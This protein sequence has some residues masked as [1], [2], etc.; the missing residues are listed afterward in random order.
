M[1]MDF[2]AHED[3]ILR[4]LKETFEKSGVEPCDY[5]PRF[6]EGGVLLYFKSLEDAEKGI[7]FF[8]SHEFRGK[9]K[10]V[11]RL[12]G[13]P[14]LEDMLHVTPS[15]LIKVTPAAFK[16]VLSLSEEELY[17]HFRAYGVLKHVEM[18][19]KRE[20]M[21]LTYRALNAAISARICM[22]MKDVATKEYIRVNYEHYSRF[23]WFSKLLSNP[24]IAIPIIAVGGTILS[25]VLI[26]PLR[27]LNVVRTLTSKDTDDAEIHVR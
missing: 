1:G 16:G 20:H 27:L 21:L 22:H 7:S 8:N 26:D 19:P 4:D 18:D 9:K 17:S 11:F 25:Y 5:F 14:W 10:H 6:K 2:T 23:G 15:P 24:R 3:Y 13:T 12:E